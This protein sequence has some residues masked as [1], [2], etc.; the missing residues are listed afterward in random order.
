MS[1]IGIFIFI[2]SSYILS[3]T[4]QTPNLMNINQAISIPHH[5]GKQVSLN[6]S[7]YFFFI[8][9]LILWFFNLNTFHRIQSRAKKKNE[10]IL[11]INLENVKDWSIWY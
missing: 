8:L 9:T 11:K 1:L 4:R 2:Q 6:L 3:K 7:I 10:L 5:A